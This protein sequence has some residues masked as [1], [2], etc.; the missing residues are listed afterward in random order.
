MP[1]LHSDT[2]TPYLHILENQRKLHQKPE[3]IFDQ[4]ESGADNRM[5]V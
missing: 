2:C 3:N 5:R 4:W 1:L